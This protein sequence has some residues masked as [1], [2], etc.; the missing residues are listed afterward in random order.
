VCVREKE[1][2]EGDRKRER[3]HPECMYVHPIS[4]SARRVQEKT[5]VVEEL[6]L[7]AVVSTLMWMLGTEPLGLMQEQ[8]VF[9]VTELSL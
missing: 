1:R 6:W 9:L 4:A 5:M 2:Y 8:E 3:L 7:Q